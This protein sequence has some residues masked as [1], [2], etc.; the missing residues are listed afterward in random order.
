MELVERIC[1]NETAMTIEQESP[2]ALSTPERDI[3]INELTIDQ[4]REVKS[5]CDKTIIEAIA[6]RQTITDEIGIRKAEAGAPVQVHSEELRTL[7]SVRDTA[8]RLG[9]EPTL[10]TGIWH[11][12]LETARRRQSD[13]RRN[14]GTTAVR[15]Q[16]T[17]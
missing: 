13:Y 14:L 16:L 2:V 4:L 7:E 1:M 17:Q 12:F 3:D 5:E 10:I 6:R 15:Q 8:I 11:S 9:L